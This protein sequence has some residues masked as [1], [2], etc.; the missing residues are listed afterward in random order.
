MLLI[1]YNHHH[2]QTNFSFLIISMPAYIVF[3]FFRIFFF[4][5]LLP[6]FY[7]SYIFS[8]C[9]TV[10]F[11][12]P[13]LSDPTKCTDKL[14][15]FSKDNNTVTYGECS[16]YCTER[17][18]LPLNIYVNSQPK[19]IPSNN[20]LKNTILSGSGSYWLSLTYG[21]V[22]TPFQWSDGK[23]KYFPEPGAAPWSSSFS[24]KNKWGYGNCDSDID[25]KFDR[26]II[27]PS[28]ATPSWK[29]VRG[30]SF[31]RYKCACQLNC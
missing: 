29:M 1:I 31:V 17:G 28:T 3:I 7:T 22:S 14:M 18:A 2:H 5:T 20:F 4:L 25:V 12:A 24:D 11:E 19:L 26:V 21:G 30:C 27:D 8:L 15:Y 10:F 6:L 16:N 23:N 13:P 9:F